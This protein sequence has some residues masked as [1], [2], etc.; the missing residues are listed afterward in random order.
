MDDVHE[1]ACHCGTVRFKV[2]LREGLRTARRCTC[3]FCRMRGAIVVSAR[4]EDFEFLAGEEN[5]ALYQFHTRT[6]QHWFCKT[7]GIYTHHR[8]RS[9]PG[10]FGV[11]VACLVG[12]SPFD[13]AE[14]QVVDG[15]L[16]PSD[17]GGASRIAGVLR[18]EPQG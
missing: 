8:R 5:L 4:S 7:C 13:F 14:V 10:L 3:S 16:H 18:F 17:S 9:D 12:I 6:A 15:V 2:W 11:N 1:A